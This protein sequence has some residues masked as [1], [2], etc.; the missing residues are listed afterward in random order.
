MLV[1]AVRWI[2]HTPFSVFLQNLKNMVPIVQTL[3]IFAIAALFSSSAVIDLR[4][5]RLL[6]KNRPLA[7]VFHR[8]EPGIWMGLV[9]LL[10]TGSLLIIAEPGRALLAW[11]FWTKVALIL[12]GIAVTLSLARMMKRSDRDEASPVAA[13]ALAVVSLLIWVGVIAAGRWIAYR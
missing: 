5:L 9:V 2:G 6:S 10:L 7:A 12:A 11:Q 3:H 8:F 1:E 4:V 13:R